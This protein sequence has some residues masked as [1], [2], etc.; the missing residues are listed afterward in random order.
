MEK[1][2]EKSIILYDAGSFILVW[3]FFGLPVGIIAD[4]LWNLLV[5]SVSL[6]R[7]P[8]SV[9]SNPGALSISTGKKLAYCIFVTTLGVV[10]DWAYF[11]L[12]WDVVLGKGQLWVPAMSQPLQFVMLIVPMI[13]LWLVNFALSYSYLKL[14][15]KQAAILGAIMAFFTAPWLLPTLPYILNWTV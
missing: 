10:I 13:M 3:V 12:T 11:E 7:L 9:N 4:Y 2:R 5:L 1:P 14:E 8:R 15:R 6:P